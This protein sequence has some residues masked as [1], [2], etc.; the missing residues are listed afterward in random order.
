MITARGVDAAVELEHDELRIIVVRRWRAA[1]ARMVPIAAI[2]S[3]RLREPADRDGYVHFEVG[4]PALDPALPEP[5]RDLTV[6]FTRAQ[7]AAFH[8]LVDAVRQQAS[9]DPR[10]AIVWSGK[11]LA[12]ASD[13]PDSAA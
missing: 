11:P 5:L 13:V 8:D 1:R 2:Q 3:F 4:G 12:A 7:A 6:R 9:A 10:L